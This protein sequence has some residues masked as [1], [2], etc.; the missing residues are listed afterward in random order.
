MID[1]TKPVQTRGGKSVRIFTTLA[2]GQPVVGQIDGSTTI[3]RWDIDG[4]FGV[5]R[6]PLQVP[7]PADLINV[8]EKRT[9]YVNIVKGAKRLKLYR[10]SQ[11]AASA[12][13]QDGPLI[14]RVKI[15]YTEGQR[16]E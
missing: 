7:H 9:A 16:D 4:T 15:E 12:F 13:D 6:P 10:T 1:F 5:S 8:P 2:D 14:A 3:N 11:E